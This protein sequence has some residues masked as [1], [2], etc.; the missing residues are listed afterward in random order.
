MRTIPLGTDSVNA[1]ALHRAGSCLRLASFGQH[2]LTEGSWTMDTPSPEI[3]KDKRRMGEFLLGKRLLTPNKQHFQMD[4]CQTSDE[5]GNTCRSVRHL[6]V[7]L[8]RLAPRLLLPWCP[9]PPPV[10]VGSHTSTGRHGTQMPL[11]HTGPCGSG[12]NPGLGAVS[13][14]LMQ[15]GVTE[16]CSPKAYS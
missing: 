16:R 13:Q 10:A 4:L 3:R 1:C 2:L 9:P 5:A 8:Q 6:A 15:C 14:P 11:P 12:G 7:H